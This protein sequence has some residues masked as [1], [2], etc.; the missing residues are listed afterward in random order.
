VTASAGGSPSGIEGV[1]CSL[2][3]GPNHWYP[4]GSARIAVGGIGQHA[5]RCAAANNAVDGAGKHGWSDWASWTLGIREPTVSGIGFAR[6]SNAVVC[7]RVRERFRVPA[8]VVTVQRHHKEVRVRKRAGSKVVIARRCHT[9]MAVRDSKRVAHG[10]R[11]TV[12]G[13]LGLANGTALGG[14]AV[15][16]LT[17][18]DNG[19][20]R[21]SQV[22]VVAT[23]SNGT[24]SLR[25]PAGPSRL[26]EA[27]Y[28]GAAALEPSVSS[29]AR[30]VVPARVKLTR[31][32][33]RR[34]AWGGTVRIVG[35]LGGGYLPPG[36]ALVRLRIGFGS[37]FTTYGVEEHVAGNGRFS[38]TYT[39]GLGDPSIHRTY[40]FQIASLPM[41]DYPWAPAASQ[42]QFVLV[43]GHPRTGRRAGRHR[44][45]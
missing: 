7:R 32:A 20:E 10:K 38:T 27:Y 5:I 30:V 21:F 9:R 18:P 6:R 35:R 8:R 42:R 43:G 3:G 40:W 37:A 24:W 26:V 14:Q 36:G 4:G 34:V 15:H 25:L 28:A 13:W 31:V 16:I 45:R 23:A 44:K 33:P 22:S 2:D 19:L 11:A 29:Q 17:A 39:F 1:A 12:S 41:G